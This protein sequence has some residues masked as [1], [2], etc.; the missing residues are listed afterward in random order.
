MYEH[1]GDIAIMNP[2]TTDT[3]GLIE[4]E[5]GEFRGSIRTVDELK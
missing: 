1:L 4:I 2:G 5:G 3:Y